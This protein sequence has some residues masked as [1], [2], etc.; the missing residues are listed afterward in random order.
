MIYFLSF[1]IAL[2]HGYYYTLVFSV[3]TA[4]QIRGIRKVIVVLVT[5]D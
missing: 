2:L 5:L 1:L 4:A 3:R